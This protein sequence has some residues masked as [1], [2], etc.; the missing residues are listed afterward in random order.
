MVKQQT[1]TISVSRQNSIYRGQNERFKNSPLMSMAK[2]PPHI[3]KQLSKEPDSAGSRGFNNSQTNY[4][5]G[6]RQ[7]SID[8]SSGRK[9]YHKLNIN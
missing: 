6:R 5:I 4:Y 9:I 2:Y 3:M 1:S 7:N 8:S